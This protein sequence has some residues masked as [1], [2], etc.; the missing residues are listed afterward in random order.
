MVSGGV[1]CPEELLAVELAAHQSFMVADLKLL[2]SLFL[3]FL[4]TGDF[5]FDCQPPQ[6]RGQPQ[7][8]TYSSFSL[9]LS[10]PSSLHTEKL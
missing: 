5:F 7:S 8:P 6:T 10:L 2:L 9:S 1:L 4:A 3:S